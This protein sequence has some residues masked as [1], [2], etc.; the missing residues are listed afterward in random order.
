MSL[1]KQTSVLGTRH[2]DHTTSKKK[3]EKKKKVSLLALAALMDLRQWFLLCITCTITTALF[4]CTAVSRAEVTRRN[5]TDRL[6]LLEVKSNTV[7][8]LGILS[9]WN[10]TVHFCHWHGVTCGRRHQRVIILELQSLQ[11]SGTISPHIGNLSFLRELNLRNNS[12]ISAIPPE[13]GLLS[14]LQVL[15]LNNNSLTGPIPQAITRCSNLTSLLLAQNMI[16]GNVPADIG[17]LSRLQKLDL[18]GNSLTGTIPPSVGNLSSLEYFMVSRNSLGGAIPNTLGNLRNLRQL[19]L[20]EN[21]FVGTVPSSIFNITSLELLDMGISQLKGSLPWDLGVTLPNLYF[22]SVAYNQF[23]G[24]IPRSVSNMSSLSFFIMA[25]N[26]FTGGVPSLAEVRGLSLFHIAVNHLGSGEADDLNF[27]CSLSNSASLQKVD[28]SQNNFG[29]AIPECIGNLSKT[30]NAFSLSDN[31]L[32]G[33]LSSSISNLINLEFLSIMGNNISG[34]I[35]PEIGDLIN[36][37]QLHLGYCQFI[38][39]IPD[40]LGN[41]T[42]MTHLSLRENNLRGTIPPSPGKCNSLILLDLGSN[43]LYGAIPPEITRLSSLSIYADFSMN[44]L[45][46]ELPM[47]IGNLKNL[48]ELDLFG[49]KLS[50]EI[51]AS[52]GS[53]ISLEKLYMQD[54]SFSGSIP[55]TLSSLRGIQAM[56]FS[57]NR[58]SGQVPQFLQDLPLVSLDLAFN[59]FEGALPMQ[60]VFTNVTATSVVGNAKLCGGLPPFQLPECKIERSNTSSRVKLIVSFTVSGILV[61]VLVMSLVYVLWRR[62]ERKTLTLSS[63]DGHLTVS[64]QSLLKAT[65]GFSSTNLIGTGSFGSVYKGAL[66]LS[67]KV[68]AIKVLN[69][70]QYGASKSFMAECQALRNIRHR[71]LVKVLTACSGFDYQG[72]DFKAL[73]YEFMANGSIDEWLHPRASGGAESAPSSRKLN[74]LQRVNIA[75]DVACAFDYLHHQSEIP[76]VHCDLKPSNVLLDDEMNGHVGDFGLARFLPAATHEF[77]RE[78]TSSVGVRIYRLYSS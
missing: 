43:K 17:S 35:P 24:P 57:N 16:E 39:E 59:D 69:L 46:G 10:S 73:I 66:D 22:L 6:T 2:K 64:Y 42:T 36:T 11:L 12:F 51:P 23:T 70:A 14:R 65:D 20:G 30:L 72:N 37:K 4:S 71:N 3:Q 33:S 48:G 9:S 27:L 13:V 60:G 47:E 45:T 18:R 50:G 15:R 77:L 56:N 31:A 52:L 53:C 74:L 49:N 1:K 32:S 40:A 38:G 19:A 25:A 54:N 44:N 75:R 58:L 61:L 26:G 34:A 21:T 28:A 67:E 62:K 78:Q 68:V 29:G 76:I 5:E 7:D 41:L 55:S 8:P 63:S